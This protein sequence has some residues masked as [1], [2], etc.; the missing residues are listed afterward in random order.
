MPSLEV[1][2]VSAHHL[3]SHRGIDT[4]ESAGDESEGNLELEGETSGPDWSCRALEHS[5]ADALLPIEI[6][7]NEQ[8]MSAGRSLWGKWRSRAILMLDS[9]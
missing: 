3:D 2:F 8:P 6:L 4:C 9:D 1:F 7:G 5:D